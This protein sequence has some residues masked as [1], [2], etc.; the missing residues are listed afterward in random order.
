[1]SVILPHVRAALPFLA[2][3][4][5]WPVRL[6]LRAYA[7]ATPR[8]EDRVG[9]ER[10]VTFVL[11][12]AWGMGGTIRT[13][14]NLAGHLAS[15][16]F[17]VEILSVFRSRRR[18]FFAFAPGVRVTALDDLRGRRRL[19]R[20]P[21]ALAHP[22]NAGPRWNLW[23]DLRLVRRLRRRT[24]FLIT[25][26]PVLNLIAADLR[27]PGL[28]LVGQEHMSH[29]IWGQRLRRAMVAAYP[30]LDV[31]VA[32]TEGDRA[33][34]EQVTA[35]M[36]RTERIP[37]SVSAL[38]GPEPDLATPVLVGAGRLTPQKGFDRLI[39][40]FAKI[41]G[42]HPAWSVR[43]YGRGGKRRAL[44]RQIDAAGLG[45]RVQLAGATKDMGAAMAHGSIFVL[46]SRL[47]GFPLILLEAMSKGLAP[48][49]FDCRTGPGDIVDD[50]RNGLLVPDGDVDALAAAMAELMADDDLRRRC[51]AAARETAR[52]YDMQGA[53]G[54]RWEALLAELFAHAKANGRH[55]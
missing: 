1:M 5:L 9:A 28:V 37:N 3:A 54:P 14:H 17:E 6:A 34:Y 18:P 4:A 53:V 50:H 42:D 16:G 7:R 25:T 41:A 24:G 40:A 38:G 51:A 20:L 13:V 19:R 44:R 31:L 33:R 36:V 52:D 39:E 43:I 46:S 29:D 11:G 49:A 12:S 26:R 15:E 48:V 8:A 32:L 47:E 23:V 10:R 45:D 2:H 22:A 30:R 27:P 21:S 55:L 35:G